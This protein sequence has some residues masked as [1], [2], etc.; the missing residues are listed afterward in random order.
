MNETVLTSEEKNWGMAAH[1]SA[2]VAVAGLPFGHVLGPLIVYLVK[3]SQ[4]PFVARH[5]RA[6]LNYQITV[7]L[8]AILFFVIGVMAFI[9]FGAAAGVFSDSTYHHHAGDE[10]AALVFVFLWI[11]AIAAIVVFV[12]VSLIFIIM[13]TMA[14]SEGRPY[15]YPFTIDFIREPK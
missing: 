2:L 1:L 8:A 6:S 10:A 11:A 14:A 9:V 7:S 4:S 12:V 5:A 3:G 13:G 15:R